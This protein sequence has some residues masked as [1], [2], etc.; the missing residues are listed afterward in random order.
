MAK[1]NKK[2]KK[3]LFQVSK[4]L[5]VAVDTLV[6][7]LQVEGFTKVLEGTG[8][9][10]SIVSEEAYQELLEAFAADR[11]AAS[12]VKEKR[13][14]IRTESEEQEEA[15]ERPAVDREVSTPKPE[16]QPEKPAAPEVPEHVELP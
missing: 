12:R 13:T 8:I 2:F 1:E 10:A 14:A 6:E 5:N 16:P 7:H 3:R 15:Y 9:N 4:E 11:A